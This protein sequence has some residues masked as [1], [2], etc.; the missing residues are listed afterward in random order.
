MV[1]HRADAKGLELY[2]RWRHIGYGQH[3]S[4]ARG[5]AGWCRPYSQQIVNRPINQIVVVVWR[6]KI[7]RTRHHLL[8]G[9]LRVA[10]FS[11]SPKIKGTRGAD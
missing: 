8:T 10:T 3:G 1:G 7:E 11:S 4:I 9:L 6:D 2:L 5:I